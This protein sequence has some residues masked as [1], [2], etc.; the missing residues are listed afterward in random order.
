M[1]L[2]LDSRQVGYDESS[3]IMLWQAIFFVFGLLTVLYLSHQPQSRH[4]DP[5]FS[6]HAPKNRLLVQHGTSP[7][8]RG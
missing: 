5:R 2:R 4:H 6:D 1:N 8:H 3:S 7:R